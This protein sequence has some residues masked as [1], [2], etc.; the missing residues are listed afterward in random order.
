M[1]QNNAKMMDIGL[2]YRVLELVELNCDI[3]NAVRLTFIRLG[4]VRLGLCR[5]TLKY[6]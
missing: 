1:T 3:Q 6:S 2:D 5:S 4:V